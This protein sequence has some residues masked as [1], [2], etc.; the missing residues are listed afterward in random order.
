MLRRRGA[1]ALLL[2]PTLVTHGTSTGSGGV[3]RNIHVHAENPWII[4]TTFARFL[5]FA[6]LEINRFIATDGP[7]GSSSSS[8]TSGSRRWPSSSA[9]SA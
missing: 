1:P 4:V 9:S 5:S 8:A 3:L 6:S 2:V 7:S